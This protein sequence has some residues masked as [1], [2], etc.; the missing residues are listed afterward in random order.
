MERKAGLILR[1]LR[2]SLA[3]YLN[4]F[5]QRCEAVIVQIFLAHFLPQMLGRIDLWTRGR[6]RDRANILRDL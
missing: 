5:F 3:E 2:Q 1:Q 6:L 4:Q